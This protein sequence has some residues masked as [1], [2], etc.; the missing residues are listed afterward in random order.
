M[1]AI[2]VVVADV[3]G[4]RSLQMAGQ[5]FGEGHVNSLVVAIDTILTVCI[6]NMSLG[7]PAG[8]R[9]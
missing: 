3:R 2:L 8:G 1:R 7:L 9:R 5:N 4:E 6:L